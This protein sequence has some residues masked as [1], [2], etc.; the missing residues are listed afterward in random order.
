MSSKQIRDSA[1]TN[2]IRLFYDVGD[3]LEKYLKGEESYANRHP[4]L[5]T[6][7]ELADLGREALVAKAT[8]TARVGGRRRSPKVPQAPKQEVAT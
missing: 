1:I 6:T 4:A 5:K 8:A 3:A 2:G 7:N